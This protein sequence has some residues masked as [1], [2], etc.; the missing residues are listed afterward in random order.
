MPRVDSLV[1]ALTTSCDRGDDLAKR[2]CRIVRDT[3]AARL[4]G[5]ILSVEGGSDA[6][7]VGAWDTS[8]RST[9][10][11]LRGCISCAGVEVDG[12][13]WYVLGSGAGKAQPQI[14]KEPV[15]GAVI[16]ESARTFKDN[17]AAK[18]WRTQIVPRLRTE[19]LIKVPTSSGAWTRDGKRG[20]N[21]EVVGFRVFDP[22]NGDIVAAS[23]ASGPAEKDRKAC[24]KPTA[25]A[26]APGTAAAPHLPVVGAVPPTP[27]FVNVGTRIEDIW[28]PP[29]TRARPL[30][31]L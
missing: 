6:F 24:G 10:L 20:L 27:L 23:P 19:L 26:D 30:S 5:S 22:C 11:I 3:L 18:A 9:P 21:V 12:E 28:R 16:D 4:R 7:E 8:K 13:R 2:Q 1:W 29:W 14:T 31:L 25:T 17:A 15:R